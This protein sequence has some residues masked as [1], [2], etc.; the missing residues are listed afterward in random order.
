MFGFLLPTPDHTVGKKMIIH[1]LLLDLT[2]RALQRLT[3]EKSPK[4]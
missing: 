4:L 2:V 1:N 3:F